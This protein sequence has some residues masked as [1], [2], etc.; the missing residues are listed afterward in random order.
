MIKDIRRS[1]DFSILILLETKVSGANASR[2]ATK[3]GFQGMFREDPQGFVGG[4]WAF[5]DTDTWVMDILYHDTRVIHMQI[6]THTGSSCF[7]SACYGRP[8]RVI[9]ERL[10]ASLMSLKSSISGPW[11]IAGDFNAVLLD[12]EV[13]GSNST[14]RVCA[15]FNGCISFCELHDAG[16]QGPPYTWRRNN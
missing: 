14:H 15:A 8:Q 7:F 4:L 12:E 1:Y 13:Y 10:W 16:F 5:W 3:F 6:S 9:R 2:V 11:M